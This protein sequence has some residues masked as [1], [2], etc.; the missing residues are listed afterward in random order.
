M[1]E[2]PH[3][4]RKASM[5]IADHPLQAHPACSPCDLPDF[6]LHALQ[7]VG[8]DRQRPVFPQAIPQKRA[9]VHTDHGALLL[10]H[11]EFES[12]FK[13]LGHRALHPHSH[14]QLPLPF[15]LHGMTELVFLQPLFHRGKRLDVLQHRKLLFRHKHPS[16][17]LFH[18]VPS[19]RE[20]LTLYLIFVSLSKKQVTIWQQLTVAVRA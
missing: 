2:V 13:K 17:S 3:P 6:P 11:L 19:F 16:N 4:A 18:V 7:A 9:F 8:S 5:K 12:L 14:H 20:R 15:L 10:I 1:P